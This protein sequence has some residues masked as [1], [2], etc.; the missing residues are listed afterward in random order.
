MKKTMRTIGK[1]VNAAVNI[2]FTATL[3]VLVVAV[4]LPQ[5]LG[6]GTHTVLTG[7]ME[8]VINP[9]DAVVVLP[10]EEGSVRMGDVVTFMPFPNAPTLVTHRVIGVGG[11]PDGT[12]YT[13]QGDA[14]NN[15]DD[16]IKAEQIVGK[17]A[18]HIPK[19]GLAFDPIK[20]YQHLIGPMTMGMLIVYGIF[21]ITTAP[22]P[23]RRKRRAARTSHS[24]L[25]SDKETHD[26]PHRRDA[27]A[28]AVVR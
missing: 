22:L 16:P 21:H 1:V 4:S 18:F 17:V 25:T 5:L 7:S 11:G 3:I 9:G 26:L 14:N 2:M 13:T 24:P 10:V 19:F 6:G 20:Q 27:P 28:A 12:V 15:V 23:G 8:P